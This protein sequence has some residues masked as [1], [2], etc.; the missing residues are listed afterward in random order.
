M[1]ICYDKKVSKDAFGVMPG[2]EDC[3]VKWIQCELAFYL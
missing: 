3:C 1:W 2:M